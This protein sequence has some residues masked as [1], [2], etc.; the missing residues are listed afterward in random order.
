MVVVAQFYRWPRLDILIFLFFILFLISYFYFR[1][2][3]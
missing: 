3:V 1:S 2:R